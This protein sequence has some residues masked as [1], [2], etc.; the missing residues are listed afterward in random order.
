MNSFILLPLFIPLLFAVSLVLIPILFPKIK[1]PQISAV[2]FS[3]TLCLLLASV[4]LWIRTWENGVLVTALGAW[5][6]PFGIAFVSDLLS[7]SMTVIISF[8]ALCVAL[9]CFFDTE[10]RDAKLGYF[11]AFQLLLAGVCGSFLSGDL[12][13]LFVWFE[14][15]LV[16]SFVMVSFESRRLQLKGALKYTVLNYLGSVVFLCGCGLI[17]ASMGS[18]NLA[19]LALTATE[20]RLSITAIAGYSFLL[21]AFAAKAGIFPLYAWMPASY[22]TPSFATSALFAALLTKVGLYALLRINT[23]IFPMSFTAI[24]SYLIVFACLTMVIGV[25]GA[26]SQTEIRRLLSFHSVSQIGYI[27]L[28]VSFFTPHALAAALIFVCHHMIVKSNL[29]LISGLIA[30]KRGEL[31]LK[32]I[33]GL[34]KDVPLLGFLFFVPALSLAGIPPFSGFLSKL[35]VIRSGF[36]GEHYLAVAITLFVSFFTLYSMLKVWNEAFW[37]PNP[38]PRPSHKHLRLRLPLL[39]PTVALMAAT[40]LIGVWPEPWLRVADRIAEEI[41]NRDIYIEAVLGRKE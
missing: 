18:L 7:A 39:L 34:Y 38:K 1:G 23:L 10:G 3:G 33:G 17:Y 16:A 8:V 27:F 35:L 11:T 31:N 41:L 9:Y 4:W 5:P 2:N 12:F 29:F 36:E 13:N 24:Q 26:A 32:M 6:I 20:W 37:K 19:D 22:H 28:A 40:V 30:K 15:M 14:L 21:I 25:W